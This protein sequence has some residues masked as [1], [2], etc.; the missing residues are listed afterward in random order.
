MQ[1]PIH[2]TYCLGLIVNLGI[3]AK[4]FRAMYRHRL[5]FFRSCAVVIVIEKTGTPLAA[6]N[7]RDGNQLD[8]AD[9]LDVRHEAVEADQFIY[10]VF[11]H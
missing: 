2:N 3:E 8:F 5:E 7:W 4:L 11:P 6:A 10:L 9:A 1:G